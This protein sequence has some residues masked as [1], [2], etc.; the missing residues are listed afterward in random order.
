MSFKDDVEHA[1]RQT[2][3]SIPAIQLNAGWRKALVVDD[4]KI[5]RSLVGDRLRVVGFSVTTREHVDGAALA[6]AADPPHV[7]I[8]DLQLVGCMLDGASFVERLRGLLG[9]R[10]PAIVLHSAVSREILQDTARR[11]GVEWCQKDPKG[12]ISGLLDM[13]CRLVPERKIGKSK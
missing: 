7:I 12:Q 1:P 11:L 8:L 13:V 2:Q 4:S 3:P 6:I 9:A 5:V 10:M